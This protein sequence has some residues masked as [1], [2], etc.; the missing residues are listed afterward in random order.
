MKEIQSV[1]RSISEGKIENNYFLM[2]NQPYFINLICKKL[3]EKLISK[4][5]REFDLRLLYGKETSVSEILETVKSYPMFGEKQL[6]IVREAQYLNKEIKLLLPYLENPLSQTVLV[7][8]Y[9]NKTLDSKNRIY[10][11]VSNNSKVIECKQLYESQVYNWIS[12]E[13][14]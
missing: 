4:N 6:V 1:L 9:V 2:G 8:C 3:E 13:A 11:Y 12:S 10:K 7:I 14:K 5:N